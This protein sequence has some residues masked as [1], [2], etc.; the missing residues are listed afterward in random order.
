[1]KKA[2]WNL[3]NTDDKCFQWCV[4]R[5]LHPNNINSTRIIELKKYQNDLN[6][7]DIEFP[8]T[9]EDI[10]KFEK[11]NPNILKISVF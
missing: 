4:L 6:F 11:Q 3:E 5:H 10:T 2:I 1:M 8:V 9:V 7:K